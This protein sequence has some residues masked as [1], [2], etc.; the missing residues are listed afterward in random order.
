VVAPKSGQ[1][2]DGADQ[3]AQLQL[4]EHVDHAGFALAQALLG[5]AE[6][7]QQQLR[8][9]QRAGSVSGHSPGVGSGHEQQPHDPKTRP[10]PLPG[11]DFSPCSGFEAGQAQPSQAGRVTIGAGKDDAH[12]G[13]PGPGAERL[14]GRV[15]RCRP[16]ALEQVTDLLDLA[17]RLSEQ[18]FA[19]GPQV[20]QPAPG[21][22]QWF[23]DVP[24]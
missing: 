6:V 13:Q 23:G 18:S 21:L 22:I 11:N 7:I 15:Q 14:L 24:A 2:D 19:S 17:D 9:L 10:F 4:V 1:A 3:L 8:P 16:H 5:V 20:P 12:R